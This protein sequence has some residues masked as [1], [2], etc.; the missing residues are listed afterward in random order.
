MSNEFYLSIRDTDARKPTDAKEQAEF[1]NQ[2]I[3]ECV[4]LGE[5]QPGRI[6]SGSFRDSAESQVS[7]VILAGLSIPAVI[8]SVGYLL[9]YLSPIIVEFMR[10]RSNKEISINHNNTKITIKGSGNFEHDLDKVI[11]KIELL[12]QP[13]II[14]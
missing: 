1:V 9:K 3:N 7:N 12:E 11:E 5:N 10:L 8:T 13:K 4:K 6:F 14:K 2:L